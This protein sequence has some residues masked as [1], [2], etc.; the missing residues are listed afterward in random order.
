MPVSVVKASGPI[1]LARLQGS[2]HMQVPRWFVS[3]RKPWKN[4][5][6][7]MAS[8][9]SMASRGEGVGQV[10]CQ[11]LSALAGSRHV[12]DTTAPSAVPAASLLPP[13]FQ[14]PKGPCRGNAT[15][16]EHWTGPR[17][18]A[19]ESHQLIFTTYTFVSDACARDSRR[20]NENMQGWNDMIGSKAVLR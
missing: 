15:K 17:L 14:N 20:S 2:K 7:K 16:E 6:G 1:C 10:A 11:N 4:E 8:T 18:V 9:S 3:C 5:V 19:N 13:S 12:K